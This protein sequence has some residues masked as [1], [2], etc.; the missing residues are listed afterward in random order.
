[1]SDFETE[2]TALTTQAGL[3]DFSQRTLIELTGGDR[4]KFL[5][6][7]CTN[8]IKKLTPGT[9]CEIFLTSAQGK[10]T[11]HGYVFCE[12]ESL[13][14]ETVPDQA[15]TILPALDRYLLRDDVA[16]HD[17]SQAWSEL[18]LAGPMA[19]VVLEKLGAADLPTERLTHR[20]ATIAD[21]TAKLR[22]V[23]WAS[24]PTYLLQVARDDAPRLREALL[25]A[26]AIECGAE[27][28]DAVR[29][30]AGTPVF[31]R[32]I[33]PANLPQELDRDS[34]AISFTK[35]CYLGQETVARIDA[36]G[37]VNKMLRGIRFPAGSNVPSTG[38][39][40][41]A[42]GKVVGSVTSATYSPKLGAPLALAYV[43]RETNQPGTQLDSPLGPAEVVP[44]PL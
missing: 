10:T 14:L 33:T 26:G 7:F 1:M 5:H 41:T 28:W 3:V 20:S 31:E 16:L 40:L 43:R 38:T 32:D 2:Y 6:N 23:D 29:I 36:L 39:E 34:L 11:G 15:E 27:A 25:A 37:H 44:L 22:A 4:A 35:G 8:D 12:D 30:E 9:G 42:A 17:R 21:S 19:P 18:L 24:V 13:I